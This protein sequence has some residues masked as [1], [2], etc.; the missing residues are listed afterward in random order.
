M[1]ANSSTYHEGLNHFAKIPGIAEKFKRL[2]NGDPSVHHSDLF[3]EA[4]KA[5]LNLMEWFKKLQSDFGQPIRELSPIPPLPHT[6]FPLI[7][8]YRD[9]ITAAFVVNYSAYLLQINSL[10]D[11]LGN[12]D[13]HLGENIALAEDICMSAVYCSRGGFCG[14]QAM[15]FAL[16]L[17]LSALPER[18]TNW[19]QHQINAFESV[20][21]SFTLRSTILDESN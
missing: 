4:E 3:S 5:R 20:Q 15:A 16:P 7:Y 14:T 18:Y 12:S 8:E 11:S 19:T 21:K 6:P 1:P 17:A 10:L 13:H 9:I 2:N